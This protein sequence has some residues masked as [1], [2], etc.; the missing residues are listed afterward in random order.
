MNST[1]TVQVTPTGKAAWPDR[2]LVVTLSSG[3]RI[4]SSRFNV[5]EN[6]KPNARLLLT[7]V[8]EGVASRAGMR[9][10]AV[11]G[12]P[13]AAAAAD[14][15]LLANLRLRADVVLTGSGD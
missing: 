6:G 9:L 13:N 2:A 7:A 12:K 8:A 1:A 4:L 14:A 10:E 11:E 3:Q 15:D 5:L